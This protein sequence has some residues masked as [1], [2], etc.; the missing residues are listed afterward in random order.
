MPR[1]K[2]MNYIHKLALTCKNIPECRGPK[3]VVYHGGLLAFALTLAVCAERFTQRSQERW[4]K[5]HWKWILRYWYKVSGA[6][7]TGKYTP[8]QSTIS[9][10]LSV[11][12]PRYLAE[13]FS[14]EE[15]TRMSSEWVQYQKGQKNRTKK[16]KAENKTGAKKLVRKRLPQY[17]MDGKARKG[18]VSGKT[19]R[20]E[21]DL[22]LYTPETKS[23]LASRTLK[24]KQG[25]QRVALEI[26]KKEVR[27]LPRGV[28]S[29]DAGIISPAFTKH[30]T[31]RN[32]SYILGV[33]GN[34]GDVFNAIEEYNWDNILNKYTLEDK[35]S[36]GR[37]EIRTIKTVKT[38]KIGEKFFNKYT[39][40]KNVYQ[41]VSDVYDAKEKEWRQNTRYFI[42]D[43]KISRWALPTILT[44]IRDHWKIETYHHTKD[45][46]LKE[47]ACHLKNHNGSR[48]LGV[49]RSVVIKIGT[50]AYSSFREFLTDFSTEPRKTAAYIDSI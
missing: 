20:T 33:K 42:G 40:A 1:S 46:S 8:S 36:H 19:G 13:H 10:Y 24:D 17:C 9:N 6:Q 43:I 48:V 18:C 23:I 34:A 21:I 15:R 39:D 2:K 4:F 12:D 31:L 44:Y 35:P 7:F 16:R 37:R 49:L 29:G 47:D 45:V 25:E 26:L 38:G 11:E 14:E 30:V 3:G 32:C 41:V 5:T 28:F 50:R 27:N 22:T